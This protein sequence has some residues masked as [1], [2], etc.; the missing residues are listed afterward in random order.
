MART[1]ERFR[2]AYNVLLSELGGTA[3]GDNLPSELDLAARLDVSRTIVR[4][5]LSRLHQEGII[6]WGG[7]DKVLLRKPIATDRL[8]TES[9]GV[10]PEEMERQ[11]LEWILR[12]DIAP[13]TTLNVT[14]LARRLGVAPHSL[15]EF[16]ASLTRFGLVR[17]GAKGGW[18]LLGFTSDY[19][20]ELSDFRLILEL[21][22]VDCVLATDDSHPIWD[23]LEQLEAAH[24]DLAAN[25]EERFHDF[26]LLDELFHSA[27]W[28]VGNN[29]FV[30]E[31]QKV[32]S[33]VF[34]Y[35]YQWDKSDELQRNSAAVQ[36]HLRLI[37]ALKGRDKPGAIA[38]AQDHIRT[39]KQT[40]LS[41]FRRHDLP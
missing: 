14:D 8:L 34:H 12:F 3:L 20:I 7:R 17:R 2:D 28:S 10:S 31:F 36:E 22:A 11:F 18:D 19:A 40:L 39:A 16:L 41:S 4:T 23:R 13:G 15:Q 29:R 6:R 30:A 38:A 27:L 26:S 21:N 25:M 33:M 32:I 24:H 1:D 5:A 35:H 37:S 9:H